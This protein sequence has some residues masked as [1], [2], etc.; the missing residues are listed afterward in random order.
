MGDNNKIIKTDEKILRLA[1][2]GQLSA[3]AEVGFLCLN[4][5]GYFKKDYQEAFK[6]LSVAAEKNQPMAMAWL[7][8]MY[9]N[10]YGVEK[11]TRLAEKWLKLSAYYGHPY[12]IKQLEKL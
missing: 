10:G 9:L 3:C 4:G 8:D 2:G 5:Y 12:A 1:N 11:D 6:Y 7:G